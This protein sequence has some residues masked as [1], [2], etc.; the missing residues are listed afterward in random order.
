[1]MFDKYDIIKLKHNDLQKLLTWR[2]NNKDKVR[3]YN[4]SLTEGVIV[5]EKHYKQYFNEK[6]MFV[7]FKCFVYE[8]LKLHLF[9]NKLTKKVKIYH[10]SELA[11]YSQ[12]EAVKDAL[13]VYA[14]L[15]AYMEYFQEDTKRVKKV[16]KTNNANKKKNKKHKNKKNVI[17][18]GRAKYIYNIDITKEQSEERVG[19]KPRKKPK[20]S[21]VVRGHWRNLKSGKK[22]WIKSYP[23]GEGRKKVKIYKM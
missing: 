17:K 20:G 4:P 9:W 22:I 23:K 7:E 12:E 1:M 2:D 3:N 21:W 16:V 15:M 13:T 11:N 14:S 19:K 10:I 5:F 8:E 18:I 6:G